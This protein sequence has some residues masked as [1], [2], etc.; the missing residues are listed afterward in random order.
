LFLPVAYVLGPVLGLGMSAVWSAQVAY[1][2]LQALV[3]AAV[4]RSRAWMDLQ[5]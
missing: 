2:S 1:R 3:F 4:W 5:V